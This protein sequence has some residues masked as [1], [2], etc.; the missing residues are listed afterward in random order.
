MNLDHIFLA[1]LIS[2]PKK[3]TTLQKEVIKSD[4]SDSIYYDIYSVV[5]TYLLNDKEVNFIDLKFGFTDDPIAIQELE[6]IQK[7]EVVKDL[8][9]IYNKLLERTRLAKIKKIPP[10]VTKQLTNNCPSKDIL[11]G[12][13]GDLL[14]ISSQ[15]EMQLRSIGDVGT[16]VYKE[17]K[18]KK[19]R[20]AEGKNNIEL[21]TGF[22]QLD[23][24]TMGF[25]RGAMW[26]L[27]AATSDGKTQM[28]VQLA[29]SVLEE[30]KTVVFF[31]L[32]DN[33]ENLVQRFLSLR[34]G[35][36]LKDI[37]TGRLT[38]KGADH[39]YKNLESLREK[40]SLFIDDTSTDI[41]DII[42][43]IRF[44]KLKYDVGL[45]VVDYITLATDVS[46][47]SG[48]KEQE[49]SMI[50]KKL[51]RTAKGHDLPILALA[52]LN[53]NPDARAQ[54]LPIRMNDIRDSKA[55]GH[56]AAVTLFINY[57]NKYTVNMDDS[58]QSF[59]KKDGELIIAKNRYGESQKVIK[60][61]NKPEVA[62]FEE[63][64]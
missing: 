22:D 44:C 49:I 13:E 53:T 35:I 1:S 38:D 18:E 26:V 46:S 59:S 2:D 31:I 39:L 28:A 4:F 9:D 47:K 8:S 64:R 16:E 54:G 57:P 21:P 56:D 20:N 36:K 24:Y 29:N 10:R 11:D 60:L 43:K 51:L 5:M 27:A 52:Q 55:P 45:V 37:M 23:N 41:N 3:V 25:Q 32:E 7:T 50:S 58:N 14:K 15:T 48:T 6:H 61:N 33:A 30:G 34:T 63:C 40:D 42:N 19:Q 17:I 62:K 12:L